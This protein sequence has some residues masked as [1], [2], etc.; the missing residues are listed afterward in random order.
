MRKFTAIFLALVLICGL[1]GCQKNP[2]GEIEP[3]TYTL[4]DLLISQAA[5]M[6]QRISMR[7]EAAYL[8]TL[9][10]QTEVTSLAHVFTVAATGTPDSAKMAAV[11]A[12]FSEVITKLCG[13]LAGDD[14]LACGSLLSFSTHMYLPEPLEQPAAMYLRYSES[15]HFVTVFT[16]LENDLVSVWAFPLFTDVAN[17]LLTDYFSGADNWEASEIEAS[18]R[19]AS[20]ADLS[21][22]VSA[23]SRSNAYYAKLVKT[24]MRTVKPLNVS[25]IYKVTQDKV[26][27]QYVSAMSQALMHR[28]RAVQVYEFPDSVQAQVEDMLSQSTYSQQLRSVTEQ[29]VYLSWPN[30]FAATYG[31]NWI[32][33]NAVLRVLLDTTMLGASAEEGEAPALVLMDL[34]GGA[35]AMVAI[36]PNEFN[37]YLY[38]YTCL[39]IAFSAAQKLLA[40]A[41]AQLLY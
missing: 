17:S 14:A 29:Q 7:A 8:A 33:A 26:V 37:A 25:H 10:E 11:D 24:A 34:G 15:C 3:S 5:S 21:A 20:G 30:S 38:S 13:Q 19:N 23:L 4:S 27:I 36:Y 9:S 1:F 32:A 35:S 31:E 18:I 28:T 12:D 2:S 22:D 40:D 39:P 41:G 16:P 6:S